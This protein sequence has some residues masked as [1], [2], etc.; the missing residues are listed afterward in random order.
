MTSKRKSLRSRIGKRNRRAGKSFERRVA[1]RIAKRF[2][3]AWQDFAD[4]AGA[5]HKQSHDAVILSPYSETFPFFYE[6]KYRKE[7]SFSSIFKSPHTSPLYQWWFEAYDSG[8]KD[9]F[10]AVAFSKP[11]QPVYW[12]SPFDISGFS[13]VSTL[14]F[15]IKD[16][17][18]AL[19]DAKL[20]IGT[21]LYIV[22][23]DDFLGNWHE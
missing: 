12:L 11:Y 7:W 13:D 3:W 6:A 21:H 19:F 14:S 5:G 10:P 4:R 18:L 20:N 22:T 8:P 17:H 16:D 2:N 1:K 15:C 9:L 23:L